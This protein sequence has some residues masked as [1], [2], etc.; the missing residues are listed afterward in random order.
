MLFEPLAR[1]RQGR[2]QSVAPAL[3]R[4]GRC[5][6]EDSLG[7]PC[8]RS[9][10]AC[11]APHRRLPSLSPPL[12]HG[13]ARARPVGETSPPPCLAF[14]EQ[15]RRR[16][17]HPDSRRGI[18]VVASRWLRQDCGVLKRV[19]YLEAHG[20]GFALVKCVK[21]T[22]E[23]KR[24]QRTASILYSTDSWVAVLLRLDLAFVR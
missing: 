24:R 4:H 5:Q 18:D 9:L 2:P 23:S 19:L 13:V 1:H 10:C 16:A 11:V 12:P 7:T 17:L 21:P 15:N 8:G 20:R 14:G 22:V 6:V 3:G